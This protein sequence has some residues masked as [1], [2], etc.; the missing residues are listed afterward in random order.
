[1]RLETRYKI[2]DSQELSSLTLPGKLESNDLLRIPVGEKGS[3]PN[4]NS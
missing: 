1:M 4:Y 3:A 2:E